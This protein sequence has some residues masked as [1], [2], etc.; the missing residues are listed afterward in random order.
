M[1]GAAY[2]L[3]GNYY[4]SSE[5]MKIFA[6]TLIFGLILTTTQLLPA[7]A[8]NDGTNVVNIAMA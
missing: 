8:Q 4:T 2:L 1:G 7:I 5:K 6:N 3:E